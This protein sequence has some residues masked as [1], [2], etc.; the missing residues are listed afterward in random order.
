MQHHRRHKCSHSV[1]PSVTSSPVATLKRQVEMSPNPIKMKSK[2][3]KKIR[4]ENNLITNV[5]EKK[6]VPLHLTIKMR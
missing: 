1:R 4:R 2:G 6:Q 3:E 5:E